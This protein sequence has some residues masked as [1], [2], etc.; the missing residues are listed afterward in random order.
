[1]GNIYY[2]EDYGVKDDVKAYYWFTQSEEDGNIYASYKL[3]KIDYN[4]KDYQKAVIHFS[5]C[6]DRYSHYYL[7]KMY[8]DPD[9]NIFDP[10]RG[11]NYMKKSAEEENSF[12]ELNLGI[13][14]LKGDVVP[15]DIK[16]SKEWLTKA[17]EHGNG[18]ADEMIK[19]MENRNWFHAKQHIRT[20]VSL[21]TAINKMK[22]GL[23]SEWEKTRLQREHDRMI[24]QTIDN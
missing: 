24:E 17:A 20:G 1:M 7:G 3:G 21:Y 14:Y 4:R 13:L 9:G 2:Q 23:K 12:A 18:F 11:I 22:R 6:N 19:N 10:Q 15:R 8:L 16:E 5:K